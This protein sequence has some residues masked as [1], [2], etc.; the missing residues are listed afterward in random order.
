MNYPCPRLE[1]AKLGISD[2]PAR[3]TIGAD[4]KFTP[5]IWKR[6]EFAKVD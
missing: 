3:G 1:V 5:T 6:I 4:L 2:P